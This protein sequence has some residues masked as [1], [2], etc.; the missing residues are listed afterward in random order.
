MII[1]CRCRVW[2]SKNCRLL[3]WTL[4]E[5][6]STFPEDIT[7]KKW[8]RLWPTTLFAFICRFLVFYVFFFF[9]TMSYTSGKF[10]KQKGNLMVFTR[11]HTKSRLI[12]RKTVSA[13]NRR[14][15]PV[16]RS[17]RCLTVDTIS[18]QDVWRQKPS[19]TSINMSPF[20]IIIFCYQVPWLK[21]HV[22]TN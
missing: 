20:A 14:E 21:A 7:Y 6:N 18:G 12:F 19:W 8:V 9:N 16:G 4:V 17:F 11:V 1:C 22:N 2:I 5:R 3:L 15:I 10:A 13:I